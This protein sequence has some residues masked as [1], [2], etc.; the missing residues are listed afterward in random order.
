MAG[1]SFLGLDVGTSGVKAVLVSESGD[2]EASAT[3][4]LTLSTPRPGWAEQN[5]EAWWAASVTSITSVVAAKPRGDAWRRSASRGR[6]TR[7]CFWIR[8]GT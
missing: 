2:I 4:P 7:Q 5:P 8:M 6:C 1:S 3:T